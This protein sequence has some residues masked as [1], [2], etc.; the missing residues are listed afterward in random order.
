ML[1]KKTEQNGQ[2]INFPIKL[3]GQN[4]KR[5]DRSVVVGISSQGWSAFRAGRERKTFKV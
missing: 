2:T 3:F 1:T 5:T 4:K